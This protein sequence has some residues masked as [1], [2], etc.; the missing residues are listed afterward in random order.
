[1]DLLKQELQKKRKA[2]RVDFA[3]RS[4]VRRSEL[5][6]KQLQQR[7]DERLKPKT[8]A[9]VSSCLESA[10]ASGPGSDPH[11]AAGISSPSPHGELSC[12]PRHE[13]TQRFRVLRQPVTLFREDDAACAE[14][15]ELAL[16]S[17]AVDAIDGL[18]MTRGQ[19]SNDSLTGDVIGT[20]KRHRSARDACP[21]LA[22]GGGGA[23]GDEDDAGADRDLKMMEAEF[24]A[25]CA[26]DKIL[27]FFNRLLN[28]WR[29][30]LHGMPEME[31][32]TAIGKWEVER[33]NQS[34]RCLGTLFEFCRKKVSVLGD[35]CQ[36]VCINYNQ[37][38][39]FAF[40]IEAVVQK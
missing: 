17:S 21:K 40:Q 14:H 24:D 16:R 34:A 37:L 11:A 33:F 5:E 28:Q 20:R 38:R 10:A 32:R 4:F 23:A 7:R 39:C 6:R 29:Q 19:Q 18:G 26:E 13:V 22:A 30:E 25:L 35:S 31:K 15:L 12:L 36:T 3:G 27:V 2:A 1:M 8:S 9:P